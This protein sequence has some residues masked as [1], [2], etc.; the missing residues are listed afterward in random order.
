MQY[1]DNKAAHCD[2]CSHA[3][4]RGGATMECKKGHR[5]RYYRPT[6]L[7]SDDFGWRRVCDD[8][9]ENS[10]YAEPQACGLGQTGQTES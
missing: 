9:R 7:L 1:I 3:I 8:Y 4:Y 10:P 2:E 6:L 5:P